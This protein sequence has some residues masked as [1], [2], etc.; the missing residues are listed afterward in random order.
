MSTLDGAE[1][2]PFLPSKIRTFWNSVVPPLAGGLPCA[3]TTDAS[4]TPTSG[5]AA[6]KILRDIEFIEVPS[7]QTLQSFYS[8]LS[9]IPDMPDGS[10]KA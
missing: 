1:S 8:L 5:S 6:T 3:R 9:S 7:R 4:P 10:M 2:E